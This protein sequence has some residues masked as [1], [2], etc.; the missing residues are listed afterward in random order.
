[1]DRIRGQSGSTALVARHAEE[2]GSA[3]LN[4]LLGA[5]PSPSALK[6]P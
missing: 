5:V 2:G 1:M 3:G 6:T 4:A